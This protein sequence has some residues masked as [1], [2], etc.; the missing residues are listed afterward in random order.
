MRAGSTDALIKLAD[1][2]DSQR[3]TLESSPVGLGAIKGVPDALASEAFRCFSKLDDRL[4]ETA[5]AAVL[6]TAA[7][8]R[9][10]ERLD[11]PK[12]EVTWTGPDA[13]GPLVTD[14]TSAIERCLEECRDTGEVLLVGYSLTVAKNSAME[15]IIELLVDASR[16]RAKIQ[17]VLHKDDE[18]KNKNELMKH[19]DK[20]VSKPQIYTWDPPAD[21]PYTKLHAKCLVVDRLQMIVTSANFTFHGLESNIELGLLVRNQRLATA[22][23]ERFDHLMNAGVLRQWKD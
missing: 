6:R 11:S 13:E 7:E 16:R 17:V 12:V 1:G 20:F 9:E 14:S 5:V 23:H 8:I 2:L 18:N 4:N 19:W 3:I 10:V 21:H 22:V 15:R